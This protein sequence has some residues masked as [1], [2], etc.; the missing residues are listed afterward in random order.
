MKEDA[1]P[2]IAAGTPHSAQRL[3]RPVVAWSPTLRRAVGEA[4]AWFV[5]VRE[6]MVRVASVSKVRISVVISSVTLS[7]ELPRPPHG[8]PWSGNG[9]TDAADPTDMPRLSRI[10]EDTRRRIV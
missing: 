9:I 1:K 4:V 7:V 3:R 5:I 6:A 8:K 2:R 10:Q